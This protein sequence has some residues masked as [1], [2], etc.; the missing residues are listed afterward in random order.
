MMGGEQTHN[1]FL[2]G[3]VLPQPSSKRRIVGAAV[4]DGQR[5]HPGEGGLLA[6][7]EVVD[8]L[9]DDDPVQSFIGFAVLPGFFGVHQ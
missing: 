6:L 1:D 9:P 5:F 3:E 2:V 8:T 4:E 7:T